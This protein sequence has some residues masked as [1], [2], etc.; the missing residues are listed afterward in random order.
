MCRKNVL[1]WLVL[2]ATI[3]TVTAPVMVVARASAHTTY[4][5][6]LA[7]LNLNQASLNEPDEPTLIGRSVLPANTFAAGPP[8][9]ARV[10]PA[11]GVMPPFDSQPVQGFSSLI[12]NPDGSYLVLSDNGYGAI[13]NSADFELRIY[14]VSLG[15][16]ATDPPTVVSHIE[17]RDPDRKLSFPIVNEFT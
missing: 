8:S 12:A 2:T 16:T 5:S 3:P 13:E 4:Q 9:G 10:V 17:L 1:F 6:D 15:D 11:N 14:R 7:G